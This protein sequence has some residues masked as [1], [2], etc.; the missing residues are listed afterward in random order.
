MTQ[1]ETGQDVLLSIFNASTGY[2]RFDPDIV[3]TSPSFGDIKSFAECLANAKTEKD[4]Q[5]FISDNP[6][7]LTGNFG[8]GDDSVLAVLTKP[9]IGTQYFA[10]Y[11]VITV[12]QGARPIHLVEIEPANVSLFTKSGDRARRLNGAFTQVRNW[13]SWISANQSTFIKDIFQKMEMLPDPPGRAVNGSYRRRKFSEIKSAWEMFSGYDG[14]LFDC[15]IIIGRWSKLTSEQRK[16]LIAQNLHD[17]YLARVI[18]FEQLARSS[19][20]RPLRNF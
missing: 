8:A 2:E 13:T 19:F 9:A 16:A 12:G 4:L 15:T 10:D 14:P 20:Q 6:R 3:E 7:I 11:A 17:S 5:S 1:Q 18:T